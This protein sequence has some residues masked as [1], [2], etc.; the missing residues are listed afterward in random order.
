MINHKMSHYMDSMLTRE[1][2]AL[3]LTKDKVLVER[4]SNCSVK[5]SILH[6]HPYY[7]F[8]LLI[9]GC[10]NYYANGKHYT[11]H[12]GE[13]FLI[14]PNVTHLMVLAEDCTLYDRIIIHIDP[15]FYHSTLYTNEA[16]SAWPGYEQQ[17]ADVIILS[18]NATAKWEIRQLCE[19]MSATAKMDKDLR[20]TM[21]YYQIAE[22]YLTIHQIIRDNSLCPPSFSNP[23]V[24][25]SIDYMESHYTDPALNINS[26]A[27]NLHIS[28]E[29]FS[30]IFKEYT[31][32]SAHSYLT[33]LRMQHCRRAIA[34]GKTILD[35]S[36][37]SGF[38]DYSSFLKTFRKLYGMTPAEYRKAL[39]VNRNS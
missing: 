23:L 19:R 30:R 27:Q 21:Y 26:L 28:R 10:V 22:L 33:H 25:M 20:D 6:A 9:S 29:H 1:K 3:A 32:E 2:A 12:S 7:E 13:F 11:L 24:T 31:C 15:D 36:T 39:R 5:R 17:E 4:Y 38:S 18:E 14:S 8:I 37:E 16:L 34:E 35:A